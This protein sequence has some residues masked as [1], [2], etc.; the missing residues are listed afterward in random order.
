[1]ELLLKDKEGKV[2][3]SVVLPLETFEQRLKEMEGGLASLSSNG[4]SVSEELLA[5]LAETTGDALTP[6]TGRLEAVEA[7]LR[8]LSDAE[9]VRL[10]ERVFDEMGKESYLEQGAKRG[11]LSDEEPPGEGDD[12]TAVLFSPK[13]HRGQPGWEYSDTLKVWVHVGEKS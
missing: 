1:M 10:V 13:D 8:A 3:G 12:E 7:H 11:Y 2:I 5:K 9:K 6:L 4:S